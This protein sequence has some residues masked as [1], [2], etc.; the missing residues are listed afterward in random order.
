MKRLLRAIGTTRW[1]RL[2]LRRRIV[3]LFYPIESG[4]AFEFS[5]PYHGVEYRGSTSV[6]QEWHV[7]FFGGYELSEAAMIGD[8]LKLIP[9]PT[10]FDIGA[11]LGGHSFVMTGVAKEVHA[12]EPY[13]PLADTIEERATSNDVTNLV[14]HRFGLGEK[15]EVLSYF[16]DD[17]SNN[18]GT[19]SFSA[20]HSKG[21]KT[22]ANLDVRKGDD[23]DL[24]LPQFVKIDVEG[25]EAMALSGLSETLSKAKPIIMM[26][27]T[28]SSWKVF[29]DYGGL[30]A[31]LKYPFSVFEICRPK[32]FLLFF[33]FGRYRLKPNENIHP[34][35]SSFN[36]L[37][38]PK[39]HEG[40]VD[41]LT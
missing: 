25:F 5:V 19:G 9:S 34:R 23:C 26:E 36:V 22:V 29:G 4:K 13:G 41:R 3:R 27:V 15:N 38:V 24:P 1:L 28:E 8:L 16:W 14:L 21:S 2:G 32:P 17:T 35:R 20:D 18:S 39:E 37:L 40:L 7:Y 10:T 12:F 6:A 11:N 30:K 31:V 33:Q